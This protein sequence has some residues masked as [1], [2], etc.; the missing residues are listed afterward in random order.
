M[1]VPLTPAAGDYRSRLTKDR[2]QDLH[3]VRQQDNE[4]TKEQ[5]IKKY[6][7]QQLAVPYL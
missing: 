4:L 6:E 1:A 3:P 5:I 7:E 2:T